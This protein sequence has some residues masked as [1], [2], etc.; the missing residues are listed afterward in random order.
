MTAGKK[1]AQENVRT[2]PPYLCVRPDKRARGRLG[3]MGTGR[4]LSEQ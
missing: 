2:A 3:E 1:P 4:G